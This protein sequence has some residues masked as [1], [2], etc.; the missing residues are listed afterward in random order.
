MSVFPERSL[1][2]FTLPVAALL[3]V[4]MALLMPT[5]PRLENALNRSFPRALNDQIVVVSI[6]DASLRDYGRIDI[7]PRE[8]Y[9]QV[10]R[11]LTDAGAEVIGLDV[12]LSDPSHDDAALNATLNQANV[13]RAISPDEVNLHD[14]SWPP[15]IGVSALNAPRVAGISEVQTGYAL[16]DSPELVPSFARQVVAAAGDP[17]PLTTAPR[18]MPYVPPEAILRKAIS[19]RDVVNGNFRFADVQHRVVLIGLTAN[20]ISGLSLPDIDARPIPGVLL[21]ARAVSALLG[22]PLTRI[23]LWLTLL[24]TITTACAVVLARDLWGFAIAAAILLLS[25]VLWS[26]NVVIP[27]AT[28]S[29]TAV[30][31]TMLVAFERWWSLR[32][33][34]TRDPLT[35]FGNRLAFTR[36]VEH[37]WTTRQSRPLSLVLVD[38]NDLRRASDQYGR[39]ASE[40]LLRVLA[41]RLQK[42]KRRSDVVF[43]W[44]PEEF[45]VLLD[46]TSPQELAAVIQNYEQE[47]QN[48]PFR[49]LKLSANVG[50]ASTGPQIQAPTDLIEAASRDRYRRK[51]QREH[52]ATTEQ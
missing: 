10:I 39:L 24:L 9:S 6:D 43:R 21:Q 4:G 42:I 38:I 8:L 17:L 5:N 37:R 13:V 48:I 32:S 19:F 22:K 26:A 47:L 18:L 23:P 31:A 14:S 27:G 7:W 49:D 3:G 33:L 11:T 29:I 35:G 15:N 28:I 34:G 20:G 46:Q 50:G 1:R 36:A 41:E 52:P 40:E 44:G 30:L 12:L 2:R 45:A 51:Y 25:G 16:Q